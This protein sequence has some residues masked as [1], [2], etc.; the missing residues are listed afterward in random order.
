MSEMRP[1]GLA[2][3]NGEHVNRSDYEYKTTID[4]CAHF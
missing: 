4:V 1:S 2:Q 3:D